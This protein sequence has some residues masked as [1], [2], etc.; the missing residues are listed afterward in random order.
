MHP[1]CRFRQAVLAAALLF[2]TLSPAL[3]DDRPATELLPDSTVLYAE[4]PRPAKLLGTI[5][6]H[7]LRSKIEALDAY[8]EAVGTDEFAEFQTVLGVIEAQIGMSW[9]EAVEAVTENGITVAVDAESEGLAIIVDARDE[10]SLRRVLETLMEIARSDARSKGNEDPYR[11]KDYR[12]LT[13]YETKNGGFAVIG[14]KLVICNKKELGK[15]ILD[16][17]LDGGVETLAASARFQEARPG[18]DAEPTAWG[19]VDI[20]FL[21]DAG[22]AQDLFKGRADNPVGEL[23]LGGLLEALQDTPFAT[24]SLDIAEEGVTLAFSMPHDPA[25]VSEAREYWFGPEA[26]GTANPLP[27][28]AA[29]LFALTTYR[30]LSQFWLRAGDLF[31]EN[32]LDGF[33]EADSNL[34][35]LFSGRDFGEEILGAFS[36][37]VQFIARRQEFG[38]TGPRPAIR[39]PAFALVFEMRDPETTQGEMRRIFQSLIGFLNVV[40]AMNGQPQLELGM[41]QDN[42]VELVTASYLPE[43]GEE[44]ADD[45]RINF[46]FAPSVGFAGKR[47]IVS[48]TSGLARQLSGSGDE[49]DRAAAATQANTAAR[50]DVGE[51][52]TVLGE[53]RSHLIAQNM[54]ENGHTREEAEAEIGALEAIA[55]YFD[56]LSLQLVTAGERIE[57]VLGLR[58]NVE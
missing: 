39:L 41:Q 28:D 35:T 17:H 18:P 9:R 21:R 32:I 38:E 23:L 10:E 54:L 48:S 3:A 15:Y 43:A 27:E 5:L 13:V 49:D 25:G 34:T 51:L 30:D 58:L 4:M 33:A 31:D 52:R 11:E 53:N 42:D 46:N 55:G 50:L 24:A 44:D 12:G 36:P 40:G 20:G 56:D 19:Y 26:T 14:R 37:Q 6:D 22:A 8:E 2:V 29:N 57:L 16:S 45:A 47:F 7:P 1:D